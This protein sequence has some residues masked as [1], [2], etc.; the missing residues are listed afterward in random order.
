MRSRVPLAPNE[1]PGARKVPARA[2]AMSLFA[3]AVPV[4]AVISFPDWTA[5][6]FGTL[7]WLTALIP[8]FLLAYYRGLRGVAVALSGGM[9]VIT[10]TQISL[11]AFQIAEPNWPLLAG[12]VVVYLVVS[13]GIAVLA[14]A[15]RR[16]RR[17]AEDL[18]LVDRLTGLANRRHLDLSLESAFAAAERGYPL[19]VVMFDLDH[20]K[21]VND[22]HGHAAGDE[23]IRVFAEVLT[24]NTRKSDLS[25][26]FGGEEFVSLLT[27]SDNGASVFFATRVLDEFRTR[28]FAWGAQTVSAGIATYQTGMGSYEIL[29]G[30]AD[31][32]L[33]D[34][35]S[36]GR[37][38]VAIA[39]SFDER[40]FHRTSSG[41][42]TSAPPAGAA[43]E[44]PA[45]GL[46]YVVDDNVELRETLRLALASAGYAVWDSGD[47]R[48]AI[49]TFVAT[50]ETE[51][52]VV[53]LS[54]VIMPDMT[55]MTM[56]DHIAKVDPLVRVIYMSGFV[57]TPVSWAGAS[58]AVVKFLE[59]PYT[60]DTL[61]TTVA[62]VLGQEPSATGAA[63][64]D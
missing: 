32:A 28:Q 2:L 52:P 16:E 27:D 64:R 41:S 10:A 55:G 7:I 60:I 34:A 25:A 43:P 39:E 11:V 8:A 45:R 31:R 19:A 42:G 12:I 37:D 18:A 36:G 9:A 38:R 13:V 14:E 63:P 17:S 59:K 6:G 56:I 21:R 23:A 33:Y 61:L 44:K 5:D 46:I 53:I 50:A 26:R 22:V 24:A 3:L 40:H 48:E 30:A 15:L 4:V 58:G 54:D 57:H 47:P 35:K 49:R 51:R 1:E 29:L 20:F 62:D